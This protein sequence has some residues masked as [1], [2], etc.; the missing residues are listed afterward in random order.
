VTA[1]PTSPGFGAALLD[2]YAEQRRDLPWRDR[3]DA[4]AVLVSEVMLQQTQVSRVTGQFTAF[5]QRFPD[6]QT[7]AAAPL[8][9]VVTSWKGLGYNRRAVALHRAAQAVMADHGGVMPTE[10]DDLQA[11]PGV[12]PYTARA[13]RAFASGLDD[14]P[15]D[16]NVR[17]VLARAV[18]GRP[19][20]GAELRATADAAV[21]PGR[22]R[23]WSA[24][25]M[26]LG[27][28]V[29]AARSPRCGSCPVAAACVWAGA[30][31]PDP[32]SKPRRP[33]EAFVGSNRYHRG[34]LLD[35]LRS[36]PLD[37]ADLAVAAGAA[38]PEQGQALA[39]Q[40]VADGLAQWEG[41]HLRLPA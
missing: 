16:T 2:W 19:L 10:L 30:G 17:R 3:D 1:P 4:Y 25:L 27:A 14:A 23:D 5:L 24:A 35:A 39:D 36:A 11:L 9:D 18:A 41:T 15:V 12:G 26:D 31:G 32:A 37:A 29:C 13:I 8:G 34:R 7:L 6:I 21:P 33:T 22:G 20:Q 40:L 38:T 28:T